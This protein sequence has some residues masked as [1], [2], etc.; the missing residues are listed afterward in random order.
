MWKVNQPLLWEHV[1]DE[2]Y[3]GA[4]NLKLRIAFEQDNNEEVSNTKVV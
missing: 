2:L 3:H 4:L 1:L